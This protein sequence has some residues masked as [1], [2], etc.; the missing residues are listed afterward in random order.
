MKDL[1]IG[2]AILL[3]AWAM[4]WAFDLALRAAS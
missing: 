2:A 1:G 4:A 3:L